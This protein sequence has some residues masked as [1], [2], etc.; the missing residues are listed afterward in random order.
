MPLV[1]SNP[2][3]PVAADRALTAV[4]AALGDGLVGAHHI[5]STAIPGVPAKPILDLLIEVRDRESLERTGATL[6]ALG[7]EGMGEFG[8]A[9]RRYFRHHDAA[10]VRTHHLHA[11]VAGDPHVA[12]H[13]AFRDYLRAHPD[14]AA[15]YGELK[16]ALE[17]AWPDLGPGY[18]QGKAPFIHS[19][20]RAAL[21]WR[22]AGASRDWGVRPEISS[23]R[24]GVRAVNVAA[25]GGPAEASLVDILRERAR[26]S[27]SLVAAGEGRVI[28]H[29]LFT[30]VTLDG[31]PDLPLLG[32]APMA[33]APGRQRQGIGTALVAA[34]LA[35]CQDEGAA[36]VVVLGH[37]AF[38]PR[39]GFGPAAAYGLACEFP[40]PPDAFMVREL[41]AGALAGRPG[42]V[43]YHAAFRGE[44]A[45]G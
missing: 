11:Y 20:E 5:G 32:L 45:A 2:T 30:P 25:F 6:T 40:A 23:D 41:R 37:P 19:H 21:D 15:A 13:L 28:G 10:G 36:A 27:V 38:Y 4:R 17:Q 29:I 9:G 42:L 34:G 35:R 24:A 39:F 22:A 43:R 1:A 12:R 26:P 16:R 7:Y 8:I 14:V 18:V 33:V 3:W 31:H 44:D